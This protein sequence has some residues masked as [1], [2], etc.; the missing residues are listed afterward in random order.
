MLKAQSNWIEIIA[1]QQ[2]LFKLFQELKK[3]EEN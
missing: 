1:N 3:I 2:E